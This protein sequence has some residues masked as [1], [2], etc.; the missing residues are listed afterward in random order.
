MCRILHSYLNLR[1]WEKCAAATCY[2]FK[3][4][5]LQAL[6]LPG[7]R[8]EQG[9]FFGFASALWWVTK[10]PLTSNDLHSFQ[11]LFS[12]SLCKP[13]R[14]LELHLASPFLTS[15]H[16]CLFIMWPQK[17]G[18]FF[19]VCADGRQKNPEENRATLGAPSSTEAAPGMNSTF[20]DKG[21]FLNPT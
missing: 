8:G 15:R 12:T 21:G 9:E 4:I 17:W 5:V 11:Q 1:L 20:K 18:H 16:Y 14:S 3:C 13:L 2:W 19:S 7:K 6:W 10:R